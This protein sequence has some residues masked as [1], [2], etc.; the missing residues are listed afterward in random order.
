MYASQIR[1]SLD[2]SLSVPTQYCGANHRDMIET[3]GVWQRQREAGFGS[4]LV[5][6]NLYSLVAG[7][8]VATSKWECATPLS[9]H[10]VEIIKKQIYKLK[11]VS[12]MLD[13][14]I[15]LRKSRLKM[16]K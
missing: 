8:Q 10:T 7:S 2:I 13:T 14:R 15:N 5:K 11:L 4:E 1:V 16:Q 6:I 12:V 9:C 3:E